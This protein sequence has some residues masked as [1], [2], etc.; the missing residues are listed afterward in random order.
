MSKELEQAR[1]LVRMLEE[2]EKASTVQ[3][4]TVERGQRIVGSSGRSYIV[5]KQIPEQEQT[6]VIADEFM[7]EN[8]V[9]DDDTANYAESSLKER[10]ERDIQPIV[11]ADFGAGNLVEHEVD[12]TTVDMQ[13]DFG[14]CQCKV[15]PMTFD[16]AREFNDLLEKENIPDWY[17]T[18]TPW[19]SEKRGLKYAI[20]VVS[21]RGC[22]GNRNYD[23]DRGVRPFCILKS[24]IFVSKGE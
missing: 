8:V 22:I 21:P 4:C 23:Y 3:L 19:S 9:F 7:A 16:E 1:E 12:L 5:L 14:T 18:C 13:K 11:E 20:A 17:W 10:I 2:K 15:R 24:D 6:M